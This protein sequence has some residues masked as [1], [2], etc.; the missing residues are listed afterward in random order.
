MNPEM[1]PILIT[2]PPLA[3]EL[4]QQ[5]MMETMFEIYSASEVCLAVQGVLSLYA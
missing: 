2:Q 3:S 5:R 4:H 1:R